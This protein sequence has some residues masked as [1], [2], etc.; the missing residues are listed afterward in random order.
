MKNNQFVSKQ[1]VINLII[2]DDKLKIFFNTKT[3]K[4]STVKWS[5]K[6]LLHNPIE[7]RQKRVDES[8]RYS[9]NY[10][11]NGTNLIIMI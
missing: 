10:T 3:G 11:E 6:S 9:I 8:L 7:T 2:L 5:S 1:E 4:E